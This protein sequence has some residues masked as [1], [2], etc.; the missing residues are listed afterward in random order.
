MVSSGSS[1]VLL[2]DPD[3]ALI[4]GKEFRFWECI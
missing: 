4:N 3:K 2:L 1:P